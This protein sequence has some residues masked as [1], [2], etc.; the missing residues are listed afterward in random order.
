MNTHSIVESAKSLA[1][2]ASREL[3]AVKGRVADGSADLAHAVSEHGAVLL[4]SA[5]AGLRQAGRGAQKHPWLA[6]AALVAGLAA[7]GGLLFS[8]RVRTQQN[9]PR[10]APATRRRRNAS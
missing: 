6:S 2:G 1:N 10:T 9:A 8:R 4:S 3:V 7:I 5:A